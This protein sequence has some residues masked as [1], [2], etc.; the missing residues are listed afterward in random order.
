[1]TA[2]QVINKHDFKQLQNTILHSDDDGNSEIYEVP[3]KY[4]CSKHG[5]VNRVIFHIL[6]VVSMKLANVWGVKPPSRG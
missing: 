3:L 6:K 4:T 2:T 1:M 5:N